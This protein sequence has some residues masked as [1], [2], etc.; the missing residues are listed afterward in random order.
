[1]IDIPKDKMADARIRFLENRNRILRHDIQKNEEEIIKLEE[2]KT[3][4]KST[5]PQ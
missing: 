1:M 2:F 3:E 4:T 5:S